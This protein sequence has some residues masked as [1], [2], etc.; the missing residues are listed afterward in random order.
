MDSII[1]MGIK[2]CG[3]TS[4]SKLLSSRLNMERF[5]TDDV[6][7]NLTGL[8]PR[9]ICNLK[10]E[11]AFKI[12]ERD[13]CK[14][15]ADYLTKEETD[16]VIATG[17][18][19]CNNSQALEILHKLGKFVFLKTEERIAC[20]RIIREAVVGADGTITN[21]PSYIAKKNPST[22]MEVREIFHPFYVERVKIYASLAD[23]SVNMDDSSK[24][25]NT[26]KILKALG[27]DF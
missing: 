15:I 5:D 18:G 27:K 26:Q 9:E 22:L 20:D 24:A 7:K 8:T 3:K 10:D 23:I 1:L 11:E 16:A 13:A 17:G 21:I 4:Q 14:Y 2:H 19:I 12:A 25:S 6:I